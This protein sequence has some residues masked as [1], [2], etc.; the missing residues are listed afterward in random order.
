MYVIEGVVAHGRHLGTS[1][2]FPT[3]NINVSSS[4][5]QNITFGVYFAKITIDKVSYKGIANLGHRPTVA[6]SDDSVLEVYIFD[7]NQDIYGKTIC[8][9]LSRFIRAEKRFNNL[10][11]L[12]TAIKNDILIAKRF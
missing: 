11:E 10:E 6:E 4:I 7:F 12:K 3:A 1:L 2:G 9:E 8:V 5:A